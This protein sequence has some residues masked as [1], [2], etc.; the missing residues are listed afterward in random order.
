MRIEELYPYWGNAHQQLL[1]AVELLTPAQLDA[2]PYD[3]ARSIR[4]MVLNLIREERYWIGHLVA[5]YAIYQPRENDYPDAPALV[6]ALTVTREITARVLEPLSPQGLRAVRT[7]PPDPA[8]N[9]PETNMPIS[10][11]FWQVVEQEIFVWG[12]IAQ[13]IADDKPRLPRW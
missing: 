7:V 10:R 1:E 11:L 3:E 2:K 4:Q 12:Q 9:R 13:R 6:E 8:T 5:G